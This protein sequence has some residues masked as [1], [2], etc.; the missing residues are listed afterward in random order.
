LDES[1]PTYEALCNYGLI[2]E[3]IACILSAVLNRGKESSMAQPSIKTVEYDRLISSTASVIAQNQPKPVETYD[4]PA[5]KASAA[6]MT[7]VILL[8]MG[9]AVLAVL[10]FL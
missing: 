3:S 4:R 5:R 10:Y 7:V 2:S 1:G 6:G 9:L 8:C